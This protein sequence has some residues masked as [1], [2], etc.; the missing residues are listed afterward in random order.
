MPH[1]STE[2][3]ISLNK[4]IV[5]SSPGRKY[6][7]IK[8]ELIC[9]RARFLLLV[10]RSACIFYTAIVWGNSMGHLVF[11]ALGLLL[12][13]RKQGVLLC[14]IQSYQ[15]GVVIRGLKNSKTPLSCSGPRGCHD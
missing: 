2:Q 7:E 14:R 13:D 4:S 5:L 3:I 11:G 6:M 15:L 9:R 1:V 12:L 10:K 8:E